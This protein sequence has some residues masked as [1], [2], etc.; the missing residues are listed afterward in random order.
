MYTNVFHHL[1]HHPKEIKLG[2]VGNPSID[3]SKIWHDQCSD[4]TYQIAFRKTYIMHG[5][6]IFD[7]VCID[8]MEISYDRR[9]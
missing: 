2:S 6:K 1:S 4:D 3:T 8:W 7:I 5:S 9:Y